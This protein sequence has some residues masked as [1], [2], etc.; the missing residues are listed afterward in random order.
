MTTTKLF[1]HTLLAGFALFNLASAPKAN[2]ESVVVNRGPNGAAFI[3]NADNIPVDAK[4]A[5]Q[6]P[7]HSFPN[8]E[9][10]GP[11]GAATLSNKAETVKSDKV[12]SVPKVIT[13][14]PNGAAVIK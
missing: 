13:R 8:V 1:T 11:H 6:T 5:P 7:A 14:G 9:T 4:A 10:K 3:V 2:A 12:V